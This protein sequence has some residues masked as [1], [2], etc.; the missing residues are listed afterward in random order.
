MHLVTE[1]CSFLKQI[2]SAGKTKQAKR[3]RL[4][5]N[6]N[7]TV[8]SLYSPV[9]PTG[10]YIFFQHM[11]FYSFQYAKKIKSRGWRWGTLCIMAGK[12]V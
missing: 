4:W 9:P 11:F 5:K 1:T 3:R 7:I 8:N 2:Q 10:K 6:S 12:K